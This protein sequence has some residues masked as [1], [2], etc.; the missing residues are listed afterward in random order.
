[1]RSLILIFVLGCVETPP[2]STACVT[3]PDSCTGDTIC[4]GGL[5]LNAFPRTYAITDVAV[6][7]PQ[8]NLRLARPW[9]WDNTPPD[10]LLAFDGT[11]P[12]SSVVYNSSSAFFAGPFELE[13]TA[14]ASVAFFAWDY[15][16]E[17]SPEF[18]LD[19]VIGCSAAPIT[20]ALLRSHTVDCLANGVTLTGKIDPRP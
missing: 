7:V 10:L 8:A 9:D 4:Y 12:I 18:Q 14:G 5:C 17:E 11:T 15:D 16:P 1:M 2:E 19:Y 20:A 6:S 13:I 3:T